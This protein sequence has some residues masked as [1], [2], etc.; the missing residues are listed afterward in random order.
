M[1]KELLG[2]ELAAQVIEKLGD[3]QLA[4]VN[5]GSW[6][7]K[8]KFDEVIADKNVYKQQSDNYAKQIDELSKVTNGNEELSKQLELIKSQAEEE[9]ATLLKQL[10][11]TKLENALKFKLNGKVHDLDLTLGLINKEQIKLD[12]KGNIVEG[13]DE[14]YKALAESKPFLFVPENEPEKETEVAPSVKMSAGN[15]T[16]GTEQELDTFAQA[17]AKIGIKK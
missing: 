16:P 2:D 11:T 15:P 4:V 5:D 8:T 1:L 13:L 12:E 9:K 7:P 17:L 6:I 14:Q 10:E 3:K